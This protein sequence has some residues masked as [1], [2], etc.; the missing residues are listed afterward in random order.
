MA[1][2]FL[3]SKAQERIA[4]THPCLNREANTTFGRLHLPVSPVCNIQCRF[5]SRSIDKT[6][7]RPG[8][9]AE[10]L[11]PEGAVEKVK[12]ALALCPQI[13]VAGIAGPGDTL[14]TED[15]LRTF[16]LVHRSFPKLTL[17]LSTNGLMLPDY[18]R[19]LYDVGVRTVTVT[20]NAVDPAIQ[21]KIISHVVFRGVR[22]VGPEAASILIRRQLEGI[23]KISALGA[24]V[25]IN[26]VLIPGV[27]DAHIETVAR[28][29]RQAGASIYNIIPLIP[30]YELA[31]CPPPTCLQIE[32]ARA[33][34]E[35]YIP[36]FRHCQHCRADACGV[37]GK[38]DVSSQLYRQPV[39]ETFSHG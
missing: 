31:D 9:T 13:T 20:V 7:Q 39:A 16:R 6:T 24:I 29:V 17:C 22:Y 33:A 30:Q 8:V 11:R 14:A 26:T 23:R 28:T 19:E 35:K 21:A 25:K 15:A 32:K 38:G 5:C 10:I 12:Q 18:A 27:N 4:A 1:E 2:K 37:P 36:V 34:A 3:F